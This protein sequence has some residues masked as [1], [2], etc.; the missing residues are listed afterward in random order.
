MKIVSLSENR[1]VEKRVAITPEIAKKYIFNGFEVF[2][3]KDYATH[4][5]FNDEEYKSKGVEILENEKDII[6][7][8]DLIV[9]L[10]L[11]PESILSNLKENHEIFNE[12]TFFHSN[13]GFSAPGPQKMVPERNVYVGF[14]AGAANVGF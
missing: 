12:I 5:G 9:Q 1:N 13:T 2:L 4:I 3:P 7:K 11:P 10:S 14:L 6:E 8:C